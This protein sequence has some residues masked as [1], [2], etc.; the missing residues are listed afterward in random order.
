L[1]RRFAL[2]CSFGVMQGRLSAQTD[3]GYQA[4][5]WETWETEFSLA[6]ARGLEHIEWVLDSWKVHENPLLTNPRAIES[7]VEES[8]V[9]VLSV[10]ADYLMDRPLD[11]TDPES[12]SVFHRLVETMQELDARWLVIPCV[13]Q[14]SLRNPEARARFLAASTSIE[15]LISG[16]NIEVTLESDLGPSDFADLLV[17]LEGS[18]FGVNYDIGNSSSLGYNLDEEFSAYGDRVSLIHIKDR[19]LGAGSVFLGQG[20]AD[21][22]GV[23]G[24]LD[25]MNFTGPVTMQAFRDVQG[26]NVLDQ[27]LAWMEELLGKD[28]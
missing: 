15:S 26:I 21:I 16:T 20:D 8:G 1:T 7:R 13:D 19:I 6:A 24:H 17:H 2:G 14:S 4:F 28:K 18:I 10:C 12:W 27:Q 5:P 23:L 3:Y 11:V 22:F 25:T 9:K